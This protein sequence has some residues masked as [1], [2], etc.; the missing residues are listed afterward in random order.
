[1]QRASKSDAQL[2]RVRNPGGILKA[3]IPAS[4]R[5]SEPGVEL[6]RAYNEGVS[7]ATKQHFPLT[8]L[9][10]AL[11]AL[12]A[13]VGYVVQQQ[14]TPTKAEGAIHFVP[15]ELPFILNNGATTQRYLPEIVA[16]GV[17]AFD[18]DG[19][20]LVDLFF[21]NG[22][23]MPS[24]Q[25][26][27]AV[28][29]NRL[30][31]NTGSGFEDVTHRAGLSGDGYA[32]GVA[33]GDFD[34]DGHPDLFVA[35]VH[36]NQLYRNRGDGRFEDISEAA[37]LLVPTDQKLRPWSVGAAFID[38]D[39]DG[40]LDL[41]VV[42]YVIWDAATEPRCVRQEV[43]DYCHPDTY[44]GLPNTLYR[45]NGDGTFRDVTEKAG[46]AEYIG[47]G[48]SVA[49]SDFD[50]DGLPDLFVAN[51]KVF[52]FLFRNRGDGGFEEMSFETGVAAAQ[53]GKPVS[54][55][56]AHFA[57]VDNDGWADLVFTAL[58][59]E[60]FPLFRNRSA[61]RRPGDGLFEDITF[62][63]NLATL[64]R[65]MG[66]WGVGLVDFDN[67]GW[68]DLFVARSDALSPEGRLGSAVRQPNSVL[69]NLQGKRFD[70]LTETAGLLGRKPQL[71]R[72]AAFADFDNDGLMDVAVSAL[73]APAELWHN[74]SRS[75]HQW[76]AFRPRGTISNR[77]GIGARFLV[78][79]GGRQY[80]AERT[81][82]V[83]YASSS[84]GP[85]H[86]GLGDADQ[87]ERV[88]IIWPSGVRQ[89]LED[90]PAG[91]VVTVTEPSLSPAPS[92]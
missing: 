78:S 26:A 91:Q 47:K 42:N 79:A 45:N 88:E 46:L 4:S 56:G 53:H 80:M 72:G 58:P 62:P 20:G 54:G 73:N 34:N 68:R 41:F 76:I 35:G 86:I 55:M 87:V 19:D 6:A 39:R 37:G 1:V 70:D 40:H 5:L 2:S 15:T 66:G 21:T 90:L 64:S 52:N 82:S 17:A 51:D 33:V 57:D 44:T 50:Q 60:T 81:F 22:A 18:Y 77:D 8:A 24:L 48:M 7:R 32:M 30:Y 12:G 83:G 74:Q 49:V 71:Y 11:A 75:G 63:S 38:Y 59:D 23:E 92:H 25:K 36:R 14:A 29:F 61:G 9:L 3:R 65:R 69:R 84:A 43:A 27:G 13:V 67:D 28:H 10:A 16:G 89:V 31:R 85:T